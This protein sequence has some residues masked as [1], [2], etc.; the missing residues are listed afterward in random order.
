[1]NEPKVAII[2]LIANAW[3]AGAT[4]VKINWPLNDGEQFFISDDGH[5]MTE[6]EFEKRFMTLAYERNS[7]I[8]AFAII[9]ESHKQKIAV[10]PAFGRNG[11]GRLAS[12]AFGESFNVQTTNGGRELTFN[13]FIDSNNQLAFRKIIEKVGAITH[14]TKIFIDRAL[15]PRLNAENAKKEIGMRFLVDPHFNVFLNGD[16]ISFEDIPEDHIHNLNVSVPEVG[17]FEIRVIDVQ[18][19]DKTTQLHGIAWHVKNRLVGECT[20]KG[21][22]SEHLIDGRKAAAK[23]YIFIVK[24]DC[25]EEAVAADWTSFLPYNEK[26]KK[27]VA[28]IYDEIRAYLLEITKEQREDTFSDIENS[29]RPLLRKMGIANREKWE[30]FIREVQEECPSIG[31]EELEKIGGLLAK[32]ETTESK[33]SLIHTLANASVNDLNNLNAILN[34]WDIDL[35]KLVLDE[36]EWRSEL[37]ERLQTKVIN[38]RTDEVQELQPLFHRGLWI[39]GPE[40]ETIEYTSNKGMTTV[41]QH[42]FGGKGVQGSLTRPDFAILPDSTVGLYT[43]PKYDHNFSEV[44]IDRLTIIEL[45]RPGIAIGREQKGQAWGY[46]KELYAKGMLKDYSSVTC[47]VLGSELEPLES[48]VTKEKGDK[49]IIIPMVYD[50]VIRRAKS[51]LLN[52]HDKIIQAPFLK[53]ERI[54]AYMD[55]KAQQVLF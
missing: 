22:G 7:D 5:G 29:T 1:M 27:A 55:D 4:E 41:I 46:V 25:L 32:L 8:G 40:Y 26:Y 52:L 18:T 20:W 53:D 3:D 51:R 14:G 35:V 48:E 16:K 39:F 43:L 33:Y 15:K 10:R 9:P 28:K 17:S 38:S 13:V 24:A 31:A 44:G 54:K 6:A 21:S 30:K 23:R 42:L 37:L 34:K 47:F 12:F 45:K 11:K 2:E 50:T 19:T 36:I 49:V